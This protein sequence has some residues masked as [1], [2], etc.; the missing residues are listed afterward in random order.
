MG[1]IEAASRS[2]GGM[3][4]GEG[5]MRCLRL[6]WAPM[7]GPMIAENAMKIAIVMCG[8]ERMDGCHVTLSAESLA[9]YRAEPVA[10]SDL[11]WPTMWGRIPVRQGEFDAV[12]VPAEWM[13][14][15]SRGWSGLGRR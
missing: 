8:R 15:V 11:S 9:R 14:R 10:L 3:G 13:R 2:T 4:I 6:P 12:W 1:A 7:I 5:D